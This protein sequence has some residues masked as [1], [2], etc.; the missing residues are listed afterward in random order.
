MQT[1][2]D[3]ELIVVDDASPDGSYD[4]CQQFAQSDARI[5]IVR[6]KFNRGLSEARNT[7]MSYARGEYLYFVDSDDM[8]LPNALEVLYRAAKE[9]G[10]DVVHSTCI[11]VR[12]EESPGVFGKTLKSA[13][14]IKPVKGF[15][16]G[17]RVQRLQEY[18]CESGTRV[19]AWVNLH[20]RDFMT[21]NKITFAPHMLSEDDPYM[22]ALQCLAEK[23]FCIPDQFY[24]YS[25]RS[26][27]I[28]TDKHLNT[29]QRGVL[30]L[31]EGYDYMQA[32]MNRMSE[33]ELPSNVRSACFNAFFNRLIGFYIFRRYNQENLKSREAM[34]LFTR[35]FRPYFAECSG[36]AAA[37]LQSYCL[38]ICMSSALMNKERH[39]KDELKNGFFVSTPRKRMQ[40]SQLQLMI[41]VSRIC[42]KHRLRMYSY[43]RTLLG[44][45]RHRGFIPWD[46]GVEFAMPRPDFERFKQV[47]PTELNANYSLDMW[48]DYNFEGFPQDEGLP[49][50]P[51][52]E[53]A[54]SPKG[55]PH[56]A[57]ARIRDNRTVMVEFEG[58]KNL[59]QGISI[60]IM[61]LDP[62]PPFDNPKQELNFE[63]AKELFTAA[64]YPA[65]LIDAMNRKTPLALSNDIINQLLKQP[66]KQR[67]LAFE[68]FLAKNWI[69]PKFVQDF[70]NVL[71]KNAKPL[72]WKFFR[73][74]I[75]LPFEWFGVA[76][77]IDFEEVLKVQYGDWHKIDFRPPHEKIC[78]NE[79]SW[80]EYFASAI[81]Q[82]I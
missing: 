60:E 17:N 24:I 31:V 44:A 43:G 28:S 11:L 1:F 40:N 8:I 26:N 6:H 38:S 72:E 66:R 55:W 54:K 79:I 42:Q 3:F 59:N 27:N 61:P 16:P 52:S 74:M 48:Y 64:N 65:M 73:A 78:S 10:A 19:T 21:R 23:F 50:I 36:A 80:K 22:F 13:Y 82:S 7:G 75:G 4:I 62:V 76:V 35:A 18:Y 47:A 45:V 34:E 57:H 58:R 41:E 12:N 29:I 68:D 77:P 25:T 63:I 51:N 71:L 39:F 70:S 9:S 56:Q 37:L 46:D 14:D 69:E 53:L 30:S 20:R 33:E 15:L 2:P 67:A 81:P 5:K 49:M 32:I